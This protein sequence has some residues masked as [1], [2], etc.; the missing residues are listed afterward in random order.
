MRL[1]RC[2]IAGCVVCIFC[3]LFWLYLSGVGPA[4]PKGVAPSP[5]NDGTVQATMGTPPPSRN[6][7][8]VLP[9]APV[10]SATSETPQPQESNFTDSRL[11]VELRAPIDFCGKVVDENSNAIS[12]ANIHFSWDETPLEDGQRESVSES[13]SGGFFTP[14]KAGEGFGSS[15]PAVSQTSCGLLL[16][17]ERTRIIFCSTTRRCW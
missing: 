15:R 9:S 8:F 5:A 7:N 10:V 17:T 16:L 12:G 11:L 4:K 3:I 1:E 2:L 13:D 6:G 14:G